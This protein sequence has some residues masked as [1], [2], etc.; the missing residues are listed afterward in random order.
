[1]FS[2]R[3]P[4]K[5][6]R[7][8]VLMGALGAAA[9]H[10]RAE[11]APQQPA[12]TQELPVAQD[13]APFASTVEAPQLPL[14][15]DPKKPESVAG[16]STVHHGDVYV[17]SQPTPPSPGRAWTPSEPPVLPLAEDPKM[18][19]PPVLDLAQDPAPFSQYVAPQPPTPIAERP[20]RIGPPL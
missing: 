19:V 13:P 15:A 14:A 1:M 2:E 11:S 5:I 12:T 8:G 6:F 20:V 9:P 17:P 10:A 16:V 18:P 7:A 3:F 4:K